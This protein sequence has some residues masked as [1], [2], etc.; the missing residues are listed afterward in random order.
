[1]GRTTARFPV[2]LTNAIIPVHDA[3][4]AGEGESSAFEPPFAELNRRAAVL[5][6][7]PRANIKVTGRTA[8]N[9]DRTSDLNI[10]VL[11]LAP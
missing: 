2:E 11:G 7:P 3:G 8:R 5:Y 4:G 6:K 1:L 10:S 9:G